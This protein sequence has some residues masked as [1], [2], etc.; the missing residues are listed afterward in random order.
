VKAHFSS[1]EEWQGVEVEWMG[2]SES[3]FIEA[4]GGGMGW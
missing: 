1:V 2:G 3:N 4:G